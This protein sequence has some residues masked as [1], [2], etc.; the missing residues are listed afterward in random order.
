MNFSRD[1]K[2]NLPLRT[3]LSSISHTKRRLQLKLEAVVVRCC[4]HAPNQC[5]I[6]YHAVSDPISIWGRKY[7]PVPP[8][9]EAKENLYAEVGENEGRESR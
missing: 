8:G 7:S 2:A 9:T 6:A 5:R 1:N 4:R 3:C